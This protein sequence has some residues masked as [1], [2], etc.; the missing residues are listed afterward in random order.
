MKKLTLFA[1]VLSMTFGVF[2]QRQVVLPKQ[3]KQT[4]KMEIKKAVNGMIPATTIST[5]QKRSAVKSVGCTLGN[6][7][8]V[9]D[10]TN[11]G[12]TLSFD[13]TMG[14]ETK[15]YFL[16]AGLADSVAV[17]YPE[18]QD[19]IDGIMGYYEQMKSLYEMFGM[20]LTEEDFFI[21]EGGTQSMQGLAPNTTYTILAMCF[22]ETDTVVVRE[23]YTTDATTLTGEAGMAT[24]NILNVSATNAFLQVAKNDQT[25]YY[26]VLFAEEDV[27]A[28][29]NLTTSDDILAYV[30]ANGSQMNKFTQDTTWELGDDNLSS[31][32]ALTPNTKYIVWVI[33][34][35]GNQEAGTPQ[36][37]D[38]TTTS[39]ALS[40]KAEF[41]EMN[42]TVLS[43]TNAEVDFKINDQTAYYYYFLDIRDT[44]LAYDQYELEGALDWMNYLISYY[45]QNGYT[46]PSYSEDATEELGGEP[47]SDYALE[48]G[49]AYVVWGFPYNGNKELGEA[50]RVEFTTD[51]GQ[52]SLKDIDFT[53]V[54]VYP[55][56]TTD[57][58][59]V[60]S[61]NAIENIE[62]VNTLGQVVYS[63]NTNQNNATI[64]VA[65]FEK[66]NYFVKVKTV[67]NVITTSKVIVK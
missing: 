58:I 12:I 6:F 46:Y 60:N 35:N 22:N 64:N 40:G 21:F 45:A 42:A 17:W 57:V 3:E 9:E 59:M 52:V 29:N 20:E 43:E 16:N 8:S 2:A 49:T 27:F 14:D 36:S 23:N 30:E 55:N 31:S 7:T 34:F 28:A 54:N 4:P 56:P 11:G 5:T 32:Y 44:L 13:V 48:P 25:A 62:I 33:P 65:N 47:E 26:H 19:F 51:G 37:A 10:W 66:G 18:D 38:F 50:K 24:M 15:A 67:D 63:N 61:K 53:A 41:T 1:L 39:S